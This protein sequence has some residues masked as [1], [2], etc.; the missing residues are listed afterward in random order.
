[1]ERLLHAFSFNEKEPLI[2]TQLDFWLFFLAVMIIFSAIHKNYLVRSFFLTAVS[3]FFYFKTSGLYVMMLG[4]SLVVNYLLGDAIFKSKSNTAKKWIIASSAFFNLSLLGYFKYAY[5]FTES[6]NE[7]FHTDFEVV[8]HLAVWANGFFGEGSFVTK[9][10]LPVGVSFFTFQSISYVVDIYRKEVQPVK[11]FFDYTFFVTF[12]P[13]LV[14]GPI[15]RARDFIPQIRQPFQLDKNDFSWAV[16]QIVKGLI[17][18]I[19]LADYIAVHF[20]DKV[21]DAPEAYPGFV[22][23]LAM[24]GYSLQIYGD[25]SGYTDIA[26]GV[27]RLMGFKLLENFNSPYK[28][29][30]VADFWRRWHKSLG[31]WLRDYL[32][33]PLGGNK[34][35]GLGTYIATTLIF[36]FLIFITQ[37]YELIFVYAGLMAIYGIGIL[38][39][40][41]FKQYVHRDLNLLI[42]MIVGGLWHGASENFVIWGAM[43]GAALVIYKYWKSI[44]PYENKQWLIVHFWKIFLTFN[45]ITFTRIWFRLEDD[46]A[47]MVMLNQIWNNFNFSMDTLGLV[48]WTFRSV[49]WVMLIG[50]IFHWLPQRIKNTYEGWFTKSPMLLQVLAVAV[51]IFIMYQAVSDTFKPFVY[52][53]F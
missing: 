23:I 1:M 13:Q 28:A 50:Y 21:A 38:V 17:K 42:T 36:V 15:V 20:I 51:I 34:S 2:F 26:I 11:D 8:N 25:F 31:S 16:I 3:L 47:P 14:A 12:F 29:V 7:M 35:G 30:S 53:Q 41:N 46:G 52:F 43:N 49:F 33:I 5:F 48:L 44:S 27:S 45:F 37:W 9:I 39:I 4:L 32:Y 18:K 40:P 22:S 24:W 19:V 6:F 10:I